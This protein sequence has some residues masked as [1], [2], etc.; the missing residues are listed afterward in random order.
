MFKKQKK[1]HE[2]TSVTLC[3]AAILILIGAGFTHIITGVVSPY[4]LPFDIVLKKSFGVRET[5]VN[6]KKIKKMPYIAAKIKY[7][8]SCEALQRKG[9]I[10]SGKVFEVRMTN[11]LKKN[12]EK[13]QAEFESTLNKP[14]LR[15]QDQLQGES[16]ISEENTNK[17][18]AY[19]RRGIA[20][21]NNGQYE[22]AISNFAKAFQKNPGFAKAYY[23]RGLVYT[24]LGQLSQGISDFTKA[25]EIKPKFNEAY[26]KRGHLNVAMGEYDQ[27]IKDFTKVIE[28]EPT[29]YEIY[30]CRSLVYYAQGEFDKAWE[31]VLKTQS[32][33]FQI[34]STFLKKLRRASGK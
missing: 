26:I 22:T 15:W 18:E 3:A 32:S 7:P 25:L 2:R 30:F 20:S 4:N 23:N 31:D 19:N 24:A 33:G 6:A 17:A 1:W 12:M 5:F 27:A 21:A 9:Y 29:R 34:P 10:E 8:L 28:T 11:K 16:E 13:W 14:Q